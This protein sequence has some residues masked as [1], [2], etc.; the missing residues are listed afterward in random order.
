MEFNLSNQLQS[1]RLSLF[2]TRI[3]TILQ[4]KYEF[5]VAQTQLGKGFLSFKLI[6][7]HEC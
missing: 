7:V 4:F 1:C 6:S 2:F 3:K 5:K